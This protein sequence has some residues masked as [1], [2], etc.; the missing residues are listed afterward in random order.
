MSF[1]LDII[2]AYAAG[3]QAAQDGALRSTCPHDPN[4][5]DPRTR[6]AFV[7]WMRGYAEITPTPVDYSG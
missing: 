4:A 3:R 1:A 5:T 6:N 7:A 2:D